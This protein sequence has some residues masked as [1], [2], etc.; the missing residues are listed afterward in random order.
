VLTNS[1]YR[2]NAKKLQEAIAE[3]DGLSAAADLVEES[4]GLR[5]KVGQEIS[6]YTW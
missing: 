3:A 4:L 2:N 6:N 1:V 5:N